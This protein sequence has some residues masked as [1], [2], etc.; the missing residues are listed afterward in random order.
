MRE[1]PRAGQF[2][3]AEG[4]LPKVFGVEMEDMF[5]ARTAWGQGGSDWTI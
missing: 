3:P 4:C 2:G 5:R 1:E